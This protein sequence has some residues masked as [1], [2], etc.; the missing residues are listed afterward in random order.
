MNNPSNPIPKWLGPV[1]IVASILMALYGKPSPGVPHWIGYAACS[2]FLLTGVSVSAQAVGNTLLPKLIG[3]L[4]MLVLGGIVSWI[5]FGA[6]ARRCS[7]SL[8]FLG[9]TTN[10]SGC[11]SA[12]ALAA[13]LFWAAFLLIACSRFFKQKTKDR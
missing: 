8:T 11:K 3:P 6:G 5:G 10:L 7:G 4:I 1:L 2:A 13:I 9:M 12:F